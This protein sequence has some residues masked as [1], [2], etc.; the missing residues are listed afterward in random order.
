MDDYDRGD[1]QFWN[2]ADNENFLK[3]ACFVYL[4]EFSSGEFYVGQKRIY[5][6]LKNSSH[7]NSNSKQSNWKTYNTSSTE[8]KNRIEAGE[9]HQRFVLACFDSYAEAI[10]AESVLIS[11]LSY[12]PE[13]LNKALITK[14][15][16]GKWNDVEHMKRIWALLEELR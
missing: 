16:F 14:F 1:W 15:R 8:V 10:H 7:I 11:M 12:K 6:G 4:I 9:E 3:S 5:R 13:C 2:D